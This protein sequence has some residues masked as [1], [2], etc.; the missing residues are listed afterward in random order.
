MYNNIQLK[1]NKIIRKYL[2]MKE[3]LIDKIIK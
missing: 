3:N 1:K 2:L